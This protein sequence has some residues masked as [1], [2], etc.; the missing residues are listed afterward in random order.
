MSAAESSAAILRYES[1]AC[2]GPMH[3]ASSASLTWSEC[4]SAVE[5]TATVEMPSSRQARITR[6]AISP[7]LAIS[8]LRKSGLVTSDFDDKERFAELDGLSVFDENGNDFS[9]KFGLDLIH[10]F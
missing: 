5:Y 2:G 8:T 9:C 6:S 1:L 7:R 3:T 10:Q 4:S